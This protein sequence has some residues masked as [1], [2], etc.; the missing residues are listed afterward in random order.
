M[1][2]MFI[3]VTDKAAEEIKKRLT[4]DQEIVRLVYETEGCGCAV[5]GVPALYIEKTSFPKDEEAEN[6]SDFKVFYNPQHQVFLADHLTIDFSEKA[7]IFQLKTP[8][9]MLNPRMRL[10]RSL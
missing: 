9:E 5:S 7:N 4:P 2:H 6:N 8:N 3:T 10:I 1:N